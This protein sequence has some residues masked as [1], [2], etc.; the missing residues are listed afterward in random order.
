MKYQEVINQLRIDIDTLDN[1]LLKLIAKRLK[2]VGEIGEL[3]KTNNISIYQ[4][5][6]WEKLLND[7]IELGKQLDLD[8]EFIKEQMNIIHKESIRI[9]ELKN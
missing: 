4:K 1:E 7:R 9:Q 6:R 3:K 8:S 2:I 5:N